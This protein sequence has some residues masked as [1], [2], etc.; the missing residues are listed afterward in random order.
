MSITI[1]TAIPADIEACGRIMHK[2][3]NGIN[4]THGF[5]NTDFP[6]VEII[7]PEETKA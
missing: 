5:E 1:R 4:E 6:T 7:S 3:F 2:A